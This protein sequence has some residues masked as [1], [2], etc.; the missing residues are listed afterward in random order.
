VITTQNVIDRVRTITG[1]KTGAVYQDPEVIRWINDAQSRVLRNTETAQVEYSGVSVQGTYAYPVANGF[2][3]VRDV[4]YDGHKL[5]RTTREELNQLNPYWQTNPSTSIGVPDLYWIQKDTIN[6]YAT[7]DTSGKTVKVTIVP[8]PTVLVNGADL[9]VVPDEMLE[10]VVTLCLENAKT[11]D[12]DWTG[13]QYF[14]QAAKA[15]MGEDAYVEAVR[16]TDSYPAVRLAPGED[17]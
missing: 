12:E 7:P 3:M 8:R 1:D 5:R 15:R 16:G 6:L 4:W 2:L 17:W 9:L 10:S 13:A 11:W 14:Q